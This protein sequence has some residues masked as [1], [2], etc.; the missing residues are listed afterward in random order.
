[1]TE[2]PFIIAEMSGNHN[3]SIDNAFKLIDHAVTA[4]VNAIKMQTYTPDTMTI[5]ENK[6]QFSIEDS[7]SLWNKKNLYHLFNEAFTPWEWHEPLFNYARD[8]GIVIFSS[9]FDETAVDF[10]EDLNVQLYKI[11][12]FECVDIPL[13][14]KVA[15]TKKTN[16]YLYRNGDPCRDCRSCRNC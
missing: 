4:G 13:I 15:S 6:D 8:K 2:F 5:N 3:K 14:K 10:L 7:T 12:S 16:D 9:P 11:A 1:M